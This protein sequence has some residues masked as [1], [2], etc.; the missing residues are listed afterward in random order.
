MCTIR[1][2]VGMLCKSM[3][4]MYGV[5]WVGNLMCSRWDFVLITSVNHPLAG[6]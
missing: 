3:I 2:G 4:C 1:G 6:L 5:N